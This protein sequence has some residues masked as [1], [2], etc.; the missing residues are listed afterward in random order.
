MRKRERD[1]GIYI[2]IYFFF[3][4]TYRVYPL[5][6]KLNAYSHRTVVPASTSPA[7]RVRSCRS[8]ASARRS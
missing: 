3:L 6:K 7:A 8:A 5:A 1:I 2:Y 4:N